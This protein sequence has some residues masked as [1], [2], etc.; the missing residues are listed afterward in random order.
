MLFMKFF[1]LFIVTI[2]CG[3]SAGC[4]L[5]TLLRYFLVTIYFHNIDQVPKSQ[6]V[7][8][9]VKGALHHFWAQYKIQ[10]N[11]VLHSTPKTMLSLQPLLED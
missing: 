9:N 5:L 4:I 1:L 2:K 6:S 11:T 3:F 8:Q 7:K 10:Y